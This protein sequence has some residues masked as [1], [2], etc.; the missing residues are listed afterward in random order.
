MKKVNLIWI[1]AL[2]FVV[3]SSLVCSWADADFNNKRSLTFTQTYLSNRSQGY[4]EIING[5]D[6]VN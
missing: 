3:C 2:M 4:S 5:L 6:V 1:I